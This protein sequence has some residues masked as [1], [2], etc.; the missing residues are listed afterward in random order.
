MDVIQAPVPELPETDYGAALIKVAASSVN[1][2]EWKDNLLRN[3]VFG[4]KL[5]D[6]SYPYVTGIDFSG[7]V[8]KAQG[9]CSHFAP[10]DEVWGTSSNSHAEYLIESCD[11]F[12]RKPKPLTLLQ[13]GTLGAAAM[14]GVEALYKA[15]APWSSKKT[16]LVVGGSSGTGHFGIQ[17]AKAFGAGKVITTCSPEHNALV[18]SLGADE[19]IDYHTLNWW[20]TIPAHSVDIVY[21]CI[22]MPNSGNHAYEVLADGGHYVALLPGKLADK[23]IAD[24]RPSVS[25]HFFILSWNTAKYMKILNDVVDAGKLTVNLGGVFK[26]LH[27]VPQLFNTSMHGHAVGKLAL[28]LVSDQQSFIEDDSD[29]RERNWNIVYGVE[30]QRPLNVEDL[31][32]LMVAVFVGGCVV[33]VAC[34]S[35]RKTTF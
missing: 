23:S 16:V 4:E 19:A 6:D 35:I 21:D 26:G 22:S 34:A 33:G 27:S 29:T 8:V 9:S 32:P 10:G 11:R 7:T 17:L 30:G 12:V 25:Q 5:T 18:K 20:E 15:G 14:T 2:C 3:A 24:S 1:P 13:A 28:S 31:L